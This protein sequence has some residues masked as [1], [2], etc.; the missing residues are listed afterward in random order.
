MV[1]Q[2]SQSRA[3]NTK[4]DEN[5]EVVKWVRNRSTF[6]ETHNDRDTQYLRS[7]V[8]DAVL[9]AETAAKIEL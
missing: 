5:G 9:R 6:S 3:N 4:V 7:D 1:Q 2:V 8:H